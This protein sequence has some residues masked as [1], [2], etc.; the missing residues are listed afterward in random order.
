MKCTNCAKDIPRGTGT[1]FIYKNG[2][3]SY[4]CSSKCY[5]NHYIMGRKINRKL[6]VQ[7]TKVAKAAPKEATTKK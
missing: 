2:D 4:Y 5:N 3:I 1:M 7:P 6:V